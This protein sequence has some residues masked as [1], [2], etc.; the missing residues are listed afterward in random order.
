LKERKRIS[1]DKATELFKKLVP[2][3]VEAKK[4]KLNFGAS[5]YLY[6]NQTFSQLIMF[7][8]EEDELEKI[9]QSHG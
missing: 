2:E 1:Q 8:N 6:L 4:Q 5:V 3:F 7:K 9:V